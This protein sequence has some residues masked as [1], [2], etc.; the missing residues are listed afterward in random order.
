MCIPAIASGVYALATAA[1]HLRD[2]LSAP[3]V[4]PLAF[5]A[6]QFRRL[7]AS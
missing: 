5:H 1:D 3:T 7:A 4:T 6:S 2:V